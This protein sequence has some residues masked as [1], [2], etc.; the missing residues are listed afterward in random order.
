MN[1]L[2]NGVAPFQRKK[3]SFAGKNHKYHI[4][5]GSRW[6]NKRFRTKLPRQICL[7]SIFVPPA[8]CRTD[9][10]RER[11]GKNPLRID[12]QKWI[13]VESWRYCRLWLGCFHLAFRIR[14]IL[15]HAKLI[16]LVRPWTVSDKRQTFLVDR[17]TASVYVMEWS[18]CFCNG[19]PKIGFP[20]PPSANKKTSFVNFW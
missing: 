20:P 7:F 17:L 14:K 10:W 12:A 19:T 3:T 2:T 4:E 9:A 5:R 11:R 16:D 15:T 6:M 8:C 18:S 1:V 13:N